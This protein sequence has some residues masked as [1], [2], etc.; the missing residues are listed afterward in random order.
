MRQLIPGLDSPHALGLMLP[1]V[2]QEDEF[3]QRL[4]SAF[5]E[6]LAPIIATLDSLEAYLDPR[7]APDDFVVWLAEWVGL[8]VDENWTSALT[9]DLVAR[10]VELYQW[11]GTA[12]GLARLVEVY[13]GAR[14]EITES[15]GVAWSAAP[16]VDAPGVAEPSLVVR[17]PVPDPSRVDMR[18]LESI[19][20][21]ATPA[22]VPYTVEVVSA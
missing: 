4:A 6:V 8:L 7:L 2:Y 9:R 16:G 19:V 15:G 5:D 14:P 21:A 17:V 13:A 12:E 22:H 1:A 11:R 3:S 20:T 18:R 10:A